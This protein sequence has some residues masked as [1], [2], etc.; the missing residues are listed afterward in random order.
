MTGMTLRL[1]CGDFGVVE[2]S[3][4][5]SGWALRTTNYCTTI[6]AITT[7]RYIGLAPQYAG[8]VPQYTGRVL[9]CMG[10]IHTVHTVH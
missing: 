2:W 8:E 6:W 5:T 9:Q 3:T 10:Q 7:T 1:S 4:W